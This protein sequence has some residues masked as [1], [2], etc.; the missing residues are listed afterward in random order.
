[1]RKSMGLTLGELVLVLVVTALIFGVGWTPRLGEAIG[2]LRRTPAPKP[3]EL[4]ITPPPAG[5]LGS[6]EPI[7][8]AELVE[9]ARSS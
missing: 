9:D 6:Q 1:M 5:G 7:E 2:R 4:D 8:E 3:S